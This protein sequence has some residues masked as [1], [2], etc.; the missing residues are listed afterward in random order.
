MADALKVE[1][2]VT[3]AA[4]A[5]PITMLRIMMLL[6]L[7]G[8]APQP[9]SVKLGSSRPV[10]ACGIVA[11]RGEQPGAIKAIG[12]R[13]LMQTKKLSGTACRRARAVVIDVRVQ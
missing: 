6:L 1:A 4:V 8:D 9:L 10:A 3:I 7:S 11:R 5:N 13:N 2:A 12:G